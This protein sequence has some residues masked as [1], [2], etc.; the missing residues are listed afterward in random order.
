MFFHILIYCDN[1]TVMQIYWNIDI[2]IIFNKI[3][4]W[5]QV[6]IFIYSIDNL[7]ISG[8]VVR[9]F[10]LCHG[11]FRQDLCLRVMHEEALYLATQ[12]KGDIRS[13]V[14]QAHVF[15]VFI[16]GL[17]IS[18]IPGLLFSPPYLVFWSIA[19]QYEDIGLSTIQNTWLL[20]SSYWRIFTL[21][22]EWKG[23]NINIT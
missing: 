19:T 5:S 2:E 3:F 7:C 23:T 17:A 13:M 12:Y 9:A 1:D 10:G 22:P 4:I 6:Q 18:S 20:S 8:T 14:V 16:Y 11:N 21:A 15:W